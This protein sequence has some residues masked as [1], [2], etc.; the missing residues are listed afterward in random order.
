MSCRRA[1]PGQF[2]IQLFHTSVDFPVMHQGVVPPEERAEF[3][4]RDH[5]SDRTGQSPQ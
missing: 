4:A 2:F 5:A 1:F 3:F